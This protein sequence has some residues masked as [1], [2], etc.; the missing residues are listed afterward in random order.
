WLTDAGN[1][2][3]DV[4][5]GPL[6]APAATDALLRAI[7]GVIETG[8]FCQRAQRVLIAGPSGVRALEPGP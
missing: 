1:Y 6:P 3:Y 5:L 7:P 8:L 4:K 2:L